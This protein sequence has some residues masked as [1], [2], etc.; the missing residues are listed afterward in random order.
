MKK[1]RHDKSLIYELRPHCYLGL[2]VNWFLRQKQ[3]AFT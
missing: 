3:N 2:V 1:I